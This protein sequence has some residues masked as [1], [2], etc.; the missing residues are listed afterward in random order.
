MIIK[1]YFN[2]KQNLVKFNKTDMN[3]IVTKNDEILLDFFFNGRSD[4]LF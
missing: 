3:I 1:L 4:K 2:D